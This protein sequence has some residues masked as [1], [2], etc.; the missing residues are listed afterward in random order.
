MRR[1]GRLAALILLGALSLLFCGC[2]GKVEEET[3]APAPSLSQ[4]AQARY[5][6]FPGGT[7]AGLDLTARFCTEEGGT[8]SGT[9]LLSAGAVESPFP[10]DEG[11]QVWV[12]GLPREGVLG[13]CLLDE[14]Q[15]ELGCAGVTFTT[16]EVIDASADQEGAGYVTLREDTQALSLVFVADG[17][18]HLWCALLLES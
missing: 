10:L 16:G 18:G 12:S 6:P 5:A 2:A 13:V 8:L 14:N 7:E 9:A 1:R 3:A 15:E 17:Q 11:G 4:E